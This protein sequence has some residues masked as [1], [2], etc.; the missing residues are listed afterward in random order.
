MNQWLADF[1][2]RLRRAPNVIRQ[3]TAGHRLIGLTARQ[4]DQ[5]M[6]KMV[7]SAPKNDSAYAKPLQFAH[8]VRNVQKHVQ[9][10]KRL[11][12][13]NR[14]FVQRKAAQK[15]LDTAVMKLSKEVKDMM[16]LLEQK[17]GSIVPQDATLII[18][19]RQKI[20]TGL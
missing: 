20:A 11:T 18:Q 15:E 16:M 7:K 8:N 6:N 19:L 9:R 5:R 10:N 12:C 4:L 17:K 13:S 2:T 3:Y 14:N 1:D